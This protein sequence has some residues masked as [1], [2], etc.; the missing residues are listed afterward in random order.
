MLEFAPTVA[1]YFPATQLSQAAL[2]DAALYLPAA[3]RVHGPPSG[4]VAPALHL[5]IVGIDRTS[6]G[7]YEMDKP[8]SVCIGVLEFSGHLRHSL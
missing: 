3:H 6:G 4:P 2:P 8:K 7:K 5:H 1:E